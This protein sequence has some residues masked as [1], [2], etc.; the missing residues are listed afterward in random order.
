MPGV[1]PAAWRHRPAR[2]PATGRT[3]LRTA[4]GVASG[5]AR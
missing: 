5:A 4:P 1:I 2:L 3:A